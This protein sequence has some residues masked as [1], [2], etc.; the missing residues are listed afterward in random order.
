MQKYD[1]LVQNLNGNVVVG[2]VVQIMVAGTNTPATIFADS[3]GLQQAGNPRT[4]ALG[5]YAFYAPNG[6]YDIFVIINGARVAHET[7]VLLYDP[8]DD[9]RVVSVV[10]GSGG[11]GGDSPEVV[12]TADAQNKITLDKSQGDNFAIT[13]SA[14]TMLLNPVGYAAGDKIKMIVRQDSTGG[15]LLAYDKLYALPKAQVPSLSGT[16]GVADKLEIDVTYNG[17]HL[18][19]LLTPYTNGYSIITPIARIGTTMYYTIGGAAGMGAFNKVQPGDKIYVIRDGMSSEVTGTIVGA[20]DGSNPVYL[21]AGQA[22]NGNRPLLQL[23]QTD[24][25]PGGANRPAYGKALL[26]FEDDMTVEIRDLRITGARNLDWDA[27]GIA[28]NTGACFMTVRNV[29]I[30]NCCNGMLW[31]NE[32]FTGGVDLYDSNLTGNGIGGV[33]TTGFN[34]QGNTHNI[35]AGYNNATFTAT[36]TS[37]TNSVYG[38]DIKTRAAL[39]VLNQVLASGSAQGRELDVPFG[40]KVHATNCIFS[41]GANAGQGNLINIGGEGVKTDRPREYIFTNCRFENMVTGGGRDITFFINFDHVSLQF[42]DCEFIG[43]AALALQ[44]DPNGDALYNGMTTQN[45]IRFYP[46]SE[47]IYTTTGGPIGPQ[48]PVG[49]FPVPMS[50]VE[51]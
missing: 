38:H 2:A 49:Y 8:E 36:R 5:E 19:Y 45:G 50:Q 51:G 44:G 42:I 17:D 48:L 47:P 41:K 33:D 13:L 6:R 22:V 30:T 39:T 15:R 40:G 14:N 43:D 32:T 24:F 1:V 3:A 37:F 28:P 12:L 26:N 31:G 46:G 10:P 18:E 4:D 16:P 11:A 34:T 23:L 35:Y 7:D 21:V 27:R 20:T 9:Q 29:E 25:A